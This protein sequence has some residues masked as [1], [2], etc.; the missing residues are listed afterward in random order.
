MAH[1][2]RCIQRVW[3]CAHP[4]C[5]SPHTPTASS[6]PAASAST[7]STAFARSTAS[8]TSAMFCVKVFQRLAWPQ[9]QQP[10]AYSVCRTASWRSTL[11]WASIPWSQPIMTN[12]QVQLDT[13]IGKHV[14]LWSSPVFACHRTMVAPQVHRD[15]RFVQGAWT[16]E[17]KSVWQKCNAKQGTNELPNQAGHVYFLI[18][19]PTCVCIVSQILHSSVLR[20]LC[21]LDHVDDCISE[22]H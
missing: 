20:R 8:T 10:V 17:G 16:A 7:A 4:T 9:S 2:V 3:V 6:M 13:S 19:P 5:P 1:Q 12:R 15:E 18:D 14:W 22:S 21:M 11:Y